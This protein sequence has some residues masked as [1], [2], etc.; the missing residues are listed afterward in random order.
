MRVCVFFSFD[1]GAEICESSLHT[2]TS[3][4]SHHMKENN[5]EQTTS[6]KTV[7]KNYGHEMSPVY[8]PL[9]AFC[10]SL[11]GIQPLGFISPCI[12]HQPF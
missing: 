4:D 3:L 2:V 7:K 5:T 12:A 6:L 9:Y 10:K 11:F 8:V 1:T